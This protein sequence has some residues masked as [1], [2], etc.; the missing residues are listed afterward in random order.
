MPPQ[1]KQRIRRKDLKDKVAI[2]RIRTRIKTRI[3][4]VASDHMDI[5]LT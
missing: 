4:V 1:T 5:A 3:K 2:V